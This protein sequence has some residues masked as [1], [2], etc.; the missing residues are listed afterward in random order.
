MPGVAEATVQSLCGGSGRS[1]ERD[2]ATT[3]PGDTGYGPAFV[4]VL[5][6]R[7]GMRMARFVVIGKA[8]H[9]ATN[10][11]YLAYRVGFRAHV[12]P[13]GVRTMCRVA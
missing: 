13:N 1:G 8:S 4:G 5:C 3:R 10:Y 9:M 11:T 12:L 6:S 2:A 7:G